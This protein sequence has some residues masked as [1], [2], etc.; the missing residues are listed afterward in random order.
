MMFMA[1]ASTPCIVESDGTWDRE[2]YVAEAV[3]DNPSGTPPC[4]RIDLGSRLEWIPTDAKV[5]LRQW[6][7]TKQTFGVERI[8]PIGDRWVLHVPELRSEEVVTVQWTGKRL[9]ASKIWR[10]PAV[11][12][13]LKSQTVELLWKAHGTPTF[14][15]DGTV[16]RSI[17]VQRI[18]HA[19]D[20]VHRHW[21]PR[22]SVDA[23]CEA[24]LDGQKLSVDVNELGCAVQV[25]GGE[26]L[27]WKLS[28]REP[29]V[30]SADEW[31]LE[32]GEVFRL[33][34]ADFVSHGIRPTE[35]MDE[36]EFRGPG[37][38]STRI[39][40]I[41]GVRV[42][43]NALAEVQYA[44]KAVSLPEPG[45][46]I[47][48]KGYRG[49]PTVIPVLLQKVRSQ[50]V[51]ASLP[52]VHALKPRKLMAA[53]KSRW[54]TPWEQALVLARYLQQL[55]IPARAYPVRP[56][57]LES[58]VEG[59]P[60]GYSGAVVRVDTKDGSVWLDPSCAAC[61]VGEIT[62]S[63]WGG[64]LFDEVSTRLPDPPKGEVVVQQHG[65]TLEVFLNGIQALEVRRW[66]TQFPVEER[67]HHLA[68]RFGGEGATL[69][70]HDGLVALGRPIKLQ[71]AV[72]SRR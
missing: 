70:S 67:P 56:A 43:N 39:E 1:E 25:D 11:K 35:H 8:F 27:S 32:A 65:P 41:A 46:G 69:V 10:E 29:N 47:E 21:W 18:E 13:H 3:V 64:V 24:E 38:L 40:K 20:G 7:D 48:F 68:R 72:Q 71:I 36:L 54:G 50:M 55:K 62:P 2:R 57:V 16:S 37:R 66:L 52:D 59:A 22:A 30:S 34:G 53:R 17:T 6:D 33:R 9:G 12:P 28:W 42:E 14:G 15:P 44:A 19:V 5:V 49:D 23:R 61:A 4:R 31:V 51:T 63:L 58:V 60:L 45:V 26:R